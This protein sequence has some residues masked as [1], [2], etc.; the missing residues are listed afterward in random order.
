[1][2]VMGLSLS[3]CFSRPPIPVPRKLKK[4]G[5]NLLSPSSPASNNGPLG[6]QEHTTPSRP[7]KLDSTGSSEDSN[8]K[9]KR[10]L[11]ELRNKRRQ[12]TQTV[13]KADSAEV[14][15]LD[16]PSQCLTTMPRKS[17]TTLLT[18][19]P[20]PSMDPSPPLQRAGSSSS[21]K[22][23]PPLQRSD[24]S[25]SIKRPP[26]SSGNRVKFSNDPI[27]IEDK[28]CSK[29]SEKLSQKDK[30]CSNCGTKYASPLSTANLG[31]T[32]AETDPG[33]VNSGSSTFTPAS[34]EKAGQINSHRRERERDMP[35]VSHA[36]VNDFS[37]SLSAASSGQ[38]SSGIDQLKEKEEAYKAHLEK[39][40]REEA[41]SF[42]SS[43]SAASSGQYSSGIDQLKEKEEA[44]KA[45]LEKKGRE[46][47]ESMSGI[48]ML[49]QKEEARK[50][51]EAKG[52]D[53][54]SLDRLREEGQHSRYQER[55]MG[56]SAPRDDKPESSTSSQ[57]PTGIDYLRKKEEAF[58]EAQ[59]KKGVKEKDLE[60]L[61][62]L[63]QAEEE[64][65]K[66]RESERKQGRQWDVPV[67]GRLEPARSKGAAASK[68]NLQNYERKD[69]VASNYEK[70]EFETRKMNQIGIDGKKLLDAIKVCMLSVV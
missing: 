22:P 6:S 47:A 50:A 67:Q 57:H 68:P 32:Q 8:A 18:A 3:L 62:E 64:E 59:R 34:I 28:V 10:E 43:S 5:S 45:H 61:P 60:R 30:F 7:Q 40:R 20:N 53:D 39:K 35:Q 17:M 65:R 46:E 49:K 23:S 41:G 44:Y 24:I 36:Y 15:H 69:L 26:S 48:E 56:I 2:Y 66:R 16:Q 52:R 55:H 25:P 13:K 14:R 19:S 11:E 29:C 63:V 9:L 37:S 51:F 70:E 12:T 58:K 38:Y 54:A 42:S 1:M 31:S 4:T 33:K 27:L 21:I